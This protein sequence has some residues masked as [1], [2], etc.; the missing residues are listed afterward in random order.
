MSKYC[1]V[2][3]MHFHKYTDYSEK[4][5][6]KWDSEQ[7]RYVISETNTDK[8][9]NSRLF[10]LLNALADV[11]DYMI[12][13]GIKLLLNAGDTFHKRAIID[14]ETFNAVS[15]VFETFRQNSLGVIS[16]A[17]NHDQSNLGDN[18]DTSIHTLSNSHH[19]IVENACVVDVHK[20]FNHIISDLPDI[21]ICC[22]PW[23]KDK[24][25]NMKFIKDF[26]ECE[27]TLSQKVLLMHCGISGG[28]IGSGNYTISD[29]YNL[30]QLCTNDFKYAHFGHYHKSQILSENSH[31]TG[32]L[33][34]N[35][36][37]DEGSN[38]GF[39]VADLDRR[40][41]LQLIPFEKYPKF[42]TITSENFEELSEEVLNANYVRIQVNSSDSDKVVSKVHEISENTSKAVRIEIEKDYSANA[43]SEISIT[44]STEEVLR[45]YVDENSEDLDKDKLLKIG[46]DIVSEVGGV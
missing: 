17:G 26:V 4:F 7:G 25:A 43:R 15:L 46:I 2:G 30:P 3:D 33:L 38:N 41:D 29:E 39:W 12:D 35:D 34:A 1:I 27:D 42:I 19:L 44:Q 16:I 28:L 13:N 36:F 21:K 40:Y 18:S 14:V 20:V 11:R 9:M 23:S 45:R 6:V 32:S 24:A 37:G 22:I 10:Y 5:P 8:V 31:Y